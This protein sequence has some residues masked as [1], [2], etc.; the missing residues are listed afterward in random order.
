MSK[1]VFLSCLRH[2]SSSRVTI[3]QI[4]RRE[5]REALESLHR[6]LLGRQPPRDTEISGRRSPITLTPPVQSSCR[7][8]SSSAISSSD[9]EGRTM[10]PPRNAATCFGR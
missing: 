3:A 5:Q 4:L 10:T 6:R 8:S 7:F 1:L 2:F 9:R